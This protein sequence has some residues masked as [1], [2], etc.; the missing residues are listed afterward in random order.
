[1]W[2]RYRRY[3]DNG[4]DCCSVATSSATAGVDV[5]K[6][7]VIVPPLVLSPRMKYHN[8]TVCL[9]HC[10]GIIHPL[11]GVRT[12]S[13]HPLNYVQPVGNFPQLLIYIL[14]NQTFIYYSDILRAQCPL[15]SKC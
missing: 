2:S 15:F 5:P 7:R 6:G 12:S 13:T 1:M 11:G 3:R 8:S 10:S 14:I 9:S 4:V